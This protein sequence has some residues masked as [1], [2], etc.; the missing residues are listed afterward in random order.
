MVHH[1][2]DRSDDAVDATPWPLSAR[3]LVSTEFAVVAVAAIAFVGFGLPL[4]LQGLAG[5]AAGQLVA[6]VGVGSLGLA[7]TAVAGWKFA[8]ALAAASRR[9]SA[10]APTD[11]TP[12]E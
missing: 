11:A 8:A 2:T 1:P 7:V 9:F 12:I 6:G 10:R 5:L 3:F 4:V